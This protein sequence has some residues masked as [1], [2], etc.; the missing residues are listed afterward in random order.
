MRT[1]LFLLGII[2]LGATFWFSNIYIS[3]QEKAQLYAANDLCNSIVGRAGQIIFPSVAQD[4]QTV[5]NYVQFLALSPFLYLVG[6]VLLVVGAASG[7]QK[8]QVVY[9][10]SPQPPLQQPVQPASAMPARYCQSCGKPME[11]QHSYCPYCGAVQGPPTPS[12]AK[13]P[14][15]ITEESIP[16]KMQKV[17]APQPS[18]SYCRRCGS[19]MLPDAMYCSKCGTGKI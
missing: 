15:T 7:G 3:A 13:T 16:E 14:T 6:L 2:L 4:C 8:P 5:S 19:Q 1:G 10:P 12:Q 11:P 9:S 17:S 18:R